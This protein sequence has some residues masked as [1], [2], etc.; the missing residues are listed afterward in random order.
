MT[1]N[2]SVPDPRQ[3]GEFS[4]HRSSTIDPD[5]VLAFS[6]KND[7][8]DASTVAPTL[9]SMGHC[10][11]RANAGGQVAVSY[12]SFDCRRSRLHIR[13]LLPVECERLQG[14]PDYWTAIPWRGKPAAE[15][16]DGPRYRA[17]GNSWP[18]PAV[19][20]IGRRIAD[21]LAGGADMRFGSVCSGIEAASVAWRPLGWRAAWFAEI[22]PFPSAVLAHRFP[23]VSNLGDM[24]Y[25]PARI[26]AG[27][28]EAPDLLCGGTPCQAFSVAGK[29][30]SLADARGNLTLT[31]CEI[32]NAID[33]VRERAGKR[34][35]VVF[36]ENVPGV[37][38]TKDNAFGCFLGKLAGETGAL[39]PPGQ[40]WK[41]AG[42]VFGPQRTIAW[43]TL[44]AQYFGLAQRR[45]RVYVVASART[46]LDP[47]S[48]LFE[49]ESLRRDT[50]PG[51]KTREGAALAARA[52]AW[53]CGHG[54]VCPGTL[55]L[56]S[57]RDGGRRG[58]GD[59]ARSRWRRNRRRE[60]ADPDM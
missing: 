21:A 29:R 48:V 20:W 14:F 50:A 56:P 51:G 1:S 36:W 52:G 9:R 26:L 43:R 15:C 33:S 25:L 7:G 35:A 49:S 46:D 47:V 2:L 55:A 30:R 18:V 45:K 13:R 17:L 19:R 39:E 44:D 4:N 5:E 24:S 12:P 54:Q 3:G 53:A 38:S 16:P 34:P 58:G 42:C 23:E 8:G 6:C 10:H 57:G 32:A 59:G 27:E 11:G 28:V 60:G 22:E 37:L 31:Y 41:N 40:K